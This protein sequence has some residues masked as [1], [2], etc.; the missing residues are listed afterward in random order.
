[1][2]IAALLSVVLGA[3]G[4]LFVASPIGTV[5]GAAAAAFGLLFGLLALSG[6]VSGRWQKTAVAGIAVSSLA[7]VVF[8]VFLAFWL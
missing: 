8:A 5:G 2:R 4:L 3:W 1:M 6:G 7:L